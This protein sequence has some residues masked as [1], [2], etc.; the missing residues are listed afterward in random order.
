M[1]TKAQAHSKPPNSRISG[2]LLMRL[3]ATI[4]RAIIPAKIAIAFSSLDMRMRSMRNS[5]A[6]LN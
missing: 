2:F 3:S 1:G 6:A 5:C 4:G